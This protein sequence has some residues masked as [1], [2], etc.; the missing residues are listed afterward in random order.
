MII[1][2]LCVLLGSKDRAANTEKG[3]TI[4]GLTFSIGNAQ[5]KQ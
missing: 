5:D 4:T 2:E 1:S 3:A